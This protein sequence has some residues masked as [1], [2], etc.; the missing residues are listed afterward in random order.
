MA[1]SR[2]EL[3]H[4]DGGVSERFVRFGA[5]PLKGFRKLARRIHKANTMPAATSSGLNKQRVAQM[6]GVAYGVGER[7][8][9][10]STPTRDRYLHFLGQ[11]FRGYFVAK[12]PHHVAIRADEHHAH[13]AAKVR[14]FGVLCYEPPSD[15]DRVC[16][17]CSQC[18]C[19]LVMIYIAAFGLLG[20]WVDHLRRTEAYGLI[21]LANKHR[22]GVGLGEKRNRA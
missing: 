22:V 17:R 7:F 2:N 12:P 3:L 8:Y 4:E 16:A 11:A 15:P 5:G 13:L 19:Q 18:S 14:E 20:S 6:F 9:G 21:R 1:G 10:R